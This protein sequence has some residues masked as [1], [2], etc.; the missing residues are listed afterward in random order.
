VERLKLDLHSIEKPLKE[1]AVLLSNL[2]KKLK[3]V[4]RKHELEI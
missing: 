2:G 3:E 4:E 1:K